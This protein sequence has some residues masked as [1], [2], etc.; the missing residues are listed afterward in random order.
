MTRRDCSAFAGAS[1]AHCLTLICDASLCKREVEVALA[2]ILAAAAGP[3]A[4]FLPLSE[5]GVGGV[6]L[7]ICAIRSLAP[8]GGG[9]RRAQ[10]IIFM[11]SLL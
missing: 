1:G 9:M 8:Q 6:V 11:N 7:S 3:D 10:S 5:P 2:A 4:T